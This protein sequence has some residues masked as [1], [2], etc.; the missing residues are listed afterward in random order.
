MALPDNLRLMIAGNNKGNVTTLDE[1]SLSR[2]ALYNVEPDAATLV[3]I[4]GPDV[5]PWV[6]KV[7]TQYPNLVFQKSTPNGITVDGDADDDDQN[8]QASV[9]DLFDSGEEMLQ[10][11]TPRTIDAVSRWL[12]KVPH[13]TLQE[14]LQTPVSIEGRD[15]TLL[16]EILEARSATLTSPRTWSRTSP[17]PWPAAE[18]ETLSRTPLPSR[19]SMTSSRVHRRLQT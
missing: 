11:T 7:L 15:T 9:A 6:A 4:L 2:F 19:R 13:A 5:N 10:L 3:N 17:R 8:A 14:Y 1:A 16:N 12:N 18:P